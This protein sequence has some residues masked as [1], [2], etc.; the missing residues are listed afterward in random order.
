LLN[1]NPNL[2][3]IAMPIIHVPKFPV[4]DPDPTMG[5][6][7]KNL[8]FKDIFHISLFSAA[9]FATGWFGSKYFL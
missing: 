9:G 4:V 7:F 2:T 5:Q 6:A 1:K 8:S 3:P